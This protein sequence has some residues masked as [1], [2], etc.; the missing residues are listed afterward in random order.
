MKK[1]IIGILGGSFNPIHLGHIQLADKLLELKVVDIVAIMPCYKHNFNKS[2]ISEDDRCVMIE[3]TI[4]HNK[5]ICLFKY[6]IDYKTNG[7]AY[8]T[9]SFLCKKQEGIENV[10]DHFDLKYII[11]LDCALE[12]DKW[13]EW[14][15]LINII[16]FVVIPRDGYSLPDKECW[17]QKEPH[18]FLKDLH[19]NDTS[20][21]K[22]R[23]LIQDFYCGYVEEDIILKHLDK[24]V[25]DYIVKK[26]LYSEV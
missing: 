7:R 6:E 18:I 9:I 25:F 12:I 11:G 1:T 26:K 14:E 19:I 13:Y 4:S 20:S 5:N 24:K 8:D 2:L 10:I 22:I 16:P 21:T 23:K 3:T 17:F 15:K